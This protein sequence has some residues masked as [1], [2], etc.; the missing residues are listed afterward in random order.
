MTLAEPVGVVAHTKE[1]LRATLA[2]CQS[3]KDWSRNG[4]PSIYIDIMPYPPSGRDEFTR[5]E[6]IELRPFI[7][8]YTLPITY[9][10][11][12]SP[13]AYHPNGSMVAVFEQNTPEG[14]YSGEELDRLFD[15]FIGLV[16]RDIT[17]KARQSEN[18]WVYPH[19]ITT[20]GPERANAQQAIAEGDCQRYYLEFEWGTLA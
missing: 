4:T 12:A 6:L 15:N 5:E 14:D 7:L 2:S 9:H 16:I 19:R 11:D 1:R 10:L 18:G 17:E 3:V 8:I 20:D 13:G